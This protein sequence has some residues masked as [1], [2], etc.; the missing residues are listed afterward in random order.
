MLT[1]EEMDIEVASELSFEYGVMLTDYYTVLRMLRPSLQGG[2]ETKRCVC[3][4][5]GDLHAR[6][7]VHALLNLG[8]VFQPLPGSP[9][10]RELSGPIDYELLSSLHA[11]TD[12]ARPRMLLQPILQQLGVARGGSSVAHPLADERDLPF[13]FQDEDAGMVEIIRNY[14]GVVDEI[15]SSV[16]NNVGD[17][18]ECMRHVERCLDL[19][20]GLRENILRTVPRENVTRALLI[21]KALVGQFEI[22]IELLRTE[23]GIVPEIH[24]ATER[25]MT[26]FTT[27][28]AKLAIAL[29]Q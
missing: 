11:S 19:L 21:A 29:K 18:T 27:R 23:L 24:V 4:Y 10:A 7:I 6:H 12:S 22:V 9:T 5:G 8:A 13:A 3:F 20:R 15:K 26:E 17:A 16:L 2:P 1:P 25:I 28:L 14:Y